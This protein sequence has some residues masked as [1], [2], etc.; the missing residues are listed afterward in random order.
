MSKS[1]VWVEDS[2]VEFLNSDPCHRAMV[3]RIGNSQIIVADI[4]DDSTYRVERT[5]MDERFADGE[6]KILKESRDLG[7]L[8]FTEITEIEQIQVVRR[9][10]YMKALEYEEVEKITEKSAK[11]IIASV[12][13]ELNENPPHWQ[14]V[15]TWYSN[16]VEAGRRIKGLYPRTRNR[17]YRKSRIPKKVVEIIEEAAKRFYKPSQPRLSSVVANVEAKIDKYNLSVNDDPDLKLEVPSYQTIRRRVYNRSYSERKKSRSGSRALQEEL[18]GR[19]SP[20]VTVRILERV[21]IDHTQLDIY[22]LHD[23]RKTLLGRPHITVLMD[24][25]SGMF[26]GLQLSFVNPSFDSVSIALL[27]A[28]LKKEDFL[29]EIGCSGSWPAHGVPETIVADNGLEFWS[30]DFAIVENELGFLVQ[31]CPIRKPE[32]KGCVENIFNIINFQVLDDLPGV[33]RKKGKSADH[34]N[35]RKSA[36]MTFSEFRL[37]LINWIT[38]QYHVQI[39]AKKGYSPLERWESSLEENLPIPAESRSDLLPKLMRNTTKTLSNG[40]ISIFCKRYTSTALKH[41]QLRAGSVEV[42][43]KYNPFDI[44]SILVLDEESNVYLQA[45]CTNTDVHGMSS[46]E[47]KVLRGILAERAKNQKGD[48]GLRRARVEA[49]EARDEAHA[50]N[51]RRKNQQTTTKGAKVEGIG[52][53][54]MKLVVNNDSVPDNVSLEELEMESDDEILEGWGVDDD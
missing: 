51:S 42:R 35:A 18:A 8:S 47:D 43:V 30:K 3:S 17:G 9:M 6:I 50:R 29:S 54:D 16:Y 45:S 36:S 4:Q 15:R 27:N 24:H 49:A 33:V 52:V 34:Y 22:L 11:K 21:E 37:Y 10:K 7:E 28:F 39:S 2:V 38:K 26:L 20:V 41:L 40:G 46:Y 5:L 25:Y 44:G 1:S 53:P 32:Y 13:K 23:D 31:F 48:I 14:S 19:D 12:A